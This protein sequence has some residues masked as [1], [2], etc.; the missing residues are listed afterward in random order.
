MLNDI[1]IVISKRQVM[2]LLIEGRDAF[3]TEARDM[4]RTGLASAAWIAVDDTESP[5]RLLHAYR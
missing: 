2:R 3:L 5:E 4:L 1:G